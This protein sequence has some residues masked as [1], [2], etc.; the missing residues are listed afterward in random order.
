MSIQG[1]FRV[2][3]GRHRAYGLSVASTCSEG[4]LCCSGPTSARSFS[5]A[6]SCVPRSSGRSPA[7]AGMAQLQTLVGDL[8]RKGGASTNNPEAAKPGVSALPES[9]SEL[10]MWKRWTARL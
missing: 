6:F 4:F 9:V 10:R 8:S 7:M 2:A 1:S 5:C 3:A